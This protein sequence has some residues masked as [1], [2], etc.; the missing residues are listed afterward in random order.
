MHGGSQFVPK[1]TTVT[2]ALLD[3]YTVVLGYL[4]GQIVN[5]EIATITQ[6]LNGFT[7]QLQDHPAGEF[8]D[9]LV[10][11]DFDST[12]NSNM[13]HCSATG[14]HELPAGSKAHVHF[15]SNGAYA[16]KCRAK[17]AAPSASVTVGGGI[18]QS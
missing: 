15:R 4:A 1:T 16:F 12:T 2:T 5:L 9:F 11:A 14:P 18:R 6:A 13:L 3:V 10:D 7:I 8:Y 17:A